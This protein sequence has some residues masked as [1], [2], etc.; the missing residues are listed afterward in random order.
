MKPIFVLSQKNW[1]TQVLTQN[2]LKC[3][4]A[5]VLFTEPF[6]MTLTH[7]CRELLFQQH[8]YHEVEQTDMDGTLMK[9]R[10]SWLRLHHSQSSTFYNEIIL[11]ANRLKKWPISIIILALIVGHT[12]A[13]CLSNSSS[14]AIVS[15]VGSISWG[16]A[17]SW[18]IFSLI[19]HH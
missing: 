9:S 2:L 13:Q 19:S 14:K 8:Y 12:V 18:F 15:L 7:K 6:N 17:F 16:D 4:R 10:E 3:L 11:S 5:H 1:I